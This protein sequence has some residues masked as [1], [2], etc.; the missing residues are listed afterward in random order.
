MAKRVRSGSRTGRRS[1]WRLLVIAFFAVVVAFLAYGFG[2]TYWLQVKDYTFTS[3]DLPAQFDGTRVAFVTDIHRGP[4]FSA[5]RVGSLVKKVNALQP[6]LVLLGGDYIFMG[7]KYA[8]SCLQELSGLRAP[9]GVF[10]VLGNHDYGGA[11][12]DEGGPDAVIKAMDDAGITL[13]RDQGVWIDKGGGR[14][15]LGGVSDYSRDAPQL[16]PA[17]GDAATNDFVLLVSHEPDYTEDLPAGIVDLTLCGH[18]HGGQVTLFGKWAFH[19]PSKYGQK[20][21]TGVV[22]NQATTVIISNGV[23]TSTIPP[24]RLF[25]RPQIVVV[26]LRRGPAG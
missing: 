21:R 20:Y 26:T 11:Q 13:L 10:G 16:A 8:E 19:V 15:R 3:P 18:T 4:F 25:C 14:I 6:D 5:D 23:G 24:I 2:E 1:T 12:E 17:A 9:L 22:K 7:T